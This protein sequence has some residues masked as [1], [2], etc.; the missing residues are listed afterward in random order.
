MIK[1]TRRHMWIAA[2]LLASVLVA[3][4]VVPKLYAYSESPAFCASC[5][6]HQ[7]EY[8]NHLHDGAH[9]STRC[10]DCHLPNDNAVVHLLRK[11]YDGIE[12]VALFFGGIA[13]DPIKL[14]QHG[15]ET[16]HLNCA[17]C[18]EGMVSRIRVSD[19]GC[20]VCHRRQMHKLTGGI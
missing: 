19:G 9:R 17:R 10:V 18:H 20:V 6:V 12:D 3:A 2:A 5:H 11:S 16:I 4:L 14:T 7:F 15:H 13:G 8:A 1:P